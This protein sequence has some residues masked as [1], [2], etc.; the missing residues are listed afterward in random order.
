MVF[1]M[2]YIRLHS[3]TAAFINRPDFVY[4]NIY[5]ITGGLP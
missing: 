3:Q 5:K 4:T 2:K 1:I